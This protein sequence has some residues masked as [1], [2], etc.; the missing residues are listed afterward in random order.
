M[1][2][3]SSEGVVSHGGST[4]GGTATGNLG[5]VL[6]EEWGP[7]VTSQFN[8]ESLLMQILEDGADHQDWDGEYV[9]E[10]LH[11]G[12]NRAGGPGGE[13]DD[14]PSPGNQG[15]NQL[16][17]GTCFY[18]T[19][20]Q[21]TSKA[22]KVAEQG[23]RSAIKGLQSDIQGGLRDLI[24]EIGIDMYGNPSGALAVVDDYDAVS[25]TVTVHSTLGASDLAGNRLAET[26]GTRY[27]SGGRNQLLMGIDIDEA[28]GGADNVRGRM[29]VNTVGSRTTFVHG[30]DAVSEATGPNLQDGDLLIRAPSSNS[31][32]TFT[33][34]ADQ[35]RISLAGLDYLADD[36]TTSHAYLDNDYFGIDRSANDIL[37]AHVRNLAGADITEP[38]LQDFLD[39]IAERSGEVPDCLLMHR[40]VRTKFAQQFTSDRRFVPQEFA[41][42]WKGEYLV[43]NP[44]DGDIHVY[45]DRLCPYRTIFAINKTYLKKYML[46]PAHLVEYDGSMLRQ[47]G[48]APVWQWAMETDLQLA[49]TKPNTLG[50]LIDVNAD[51][52]F[53]VAGFRPEL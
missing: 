31:D 51:A 2:I 15:F 44:G 7:E 20:G 39:A 53:G 46:S 47:N 29:Y 11:T 10:P 43:Y 37:D 48:N 35:M 16:Q 50:K 33:N 28:D 22:M 13:T 32:D 41:G 17:I 4:T 36:G 8:N 12:R 18:R 25:D 26:H 38:V 23:N 21:I 3:D 42:G 9:V 1:A 45:V 24:M 30:S 6:M 52:T 5:P 27:L 40:S 19:T 34:A 14:Y 49:C